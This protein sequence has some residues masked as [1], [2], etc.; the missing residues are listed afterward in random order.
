MARRKAADIIADGDDDQAEV[1]IDDELTQ[2]IG[3][4]DDA[5]SSVVRVQRIREGKRP[6]FQGEVSAAGFS[7]TLLQERFGAGEYILTV[8]DSARRYRKQ[9]TVAIDAPFAQASPADPAPSELGQLVAALQ[10]SMKQQADLFAQMLQ[11]APAQAAPAV[12]PQAMRQNLL[13]DLALM[14]QLVGGG[15]QQGVGPEKLIEF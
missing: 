14:K 2:V 5:G 3:E 11:R 15:V 9:S 8:L 1:L 6:A 13:Q 10:A 7:L 12:D 4:L